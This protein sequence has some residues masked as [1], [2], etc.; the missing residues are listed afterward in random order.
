VPVTTVTVIVPVDPFGP[1]AVIVA[2]PPL[3]PVT[4]PVLASTAATFALLLVYVTPVL[5]FARKVMLL[6]ARM[7]G[8]LPVPLLPLPLPVG[9][10]TVMVTAFTVTLVVPLL[11][12]KLPSPLYAAVIVWF[13]PTG[14]AVVT[15]VAI[16]MP[17]T[18]PLPRAVLPAVKLTVPVGVPPLLVTVAVSV[19]LCPEVLV[20]GMAVTLVVVLAT[21]TLWVT[22]PLLVR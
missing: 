9:A 5:G 2:V 21:V 7:L 16:P 17:F 8:A 22:L 11:G 18:V 10:V 4:T 6:P 15:R 12:V 13:A 1:L 3:M 14:R 20:G 19:T